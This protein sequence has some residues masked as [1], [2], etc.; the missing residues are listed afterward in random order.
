ML[1]E[2]GR[3]KE[4]ETVY[5]AD[6]ARNPENGWSLFGLGCALRMQK[7][8]DEALAI[9]ARFAKAWRRADVTL[10]ASRF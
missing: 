2:A 5:W 8:D 9:E 4:A 6:L 3:A 7:R 1:L 10:A